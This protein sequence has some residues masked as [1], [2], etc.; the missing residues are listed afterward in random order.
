MCVLMR[1]HRVM[2]RFYT[3][4]PPCCIRALRKQCQLSAWMR[5]Y[6]KLYSPLYINKVIYLTPTDAVYIKY[7][8]KSTRS[9]APL[10]ARWKCRKTFTCLWLSA[11]I[12]F[13]KFLSAP[14][15]YDAVSGWP[16]RS[17]IYL[18]LLII[19]ALPHQTRT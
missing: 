15:M 4:H 13:Y 2:V 6:I 3:L 9:E 5:W 16:M 17:W 12:C 11:P 1:F 19:F 7:K 10:K 14:C 8:W 18:F